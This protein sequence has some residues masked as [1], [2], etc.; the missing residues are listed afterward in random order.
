MDQIITA[1]IK[2]LKYIFVCLEELE[3]FEELREYIFLQYYN[4]IRGGS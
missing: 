2:D 3:E 1:L 4:F